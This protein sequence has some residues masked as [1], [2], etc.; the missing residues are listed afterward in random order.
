MLALLMCSVLNLLTGFGMVNSGERVARRSRVVDDGQ[1]R[2]KN[3]GPHEGCEIKWKQQDRWYTFE[4]PVP[5]P[6]L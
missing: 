6:F 5:T 4:I 1:R 2:L 3:R